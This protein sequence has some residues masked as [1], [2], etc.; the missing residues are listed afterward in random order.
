MTHSV[1]CQARADQHQAEIAAWKA[2]WP[3]HCT[4]CNGQGGSHS[5]FDPSPSG[6]A[7]GAGSLADFDPCQSCGDK[8]LCP[9][10]GAQAWKEGDEAFGEACT[11]CGWTGKDG[12]CPPPAECI[13]WDLLDF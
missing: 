6:V 8:G 11:A 10:C 4:A 1:D 2:A 3:N 12:G 7:L 9:R 5:S 13:C